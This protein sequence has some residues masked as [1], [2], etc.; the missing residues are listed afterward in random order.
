MEVSLDHDDVVTSVK[1]YVFVVFCNQCGRA[2]LN[3]KIMVEH[4]IYSDHNRP[5]RIKDNYRTDLE[6]GLDLYHHLGSFYYFD[7]YLLVNGWLR[8]TL[9]F[10]FLEYNVLIVFVMICSTIQHH[11]TSFSF[12]VCCFFF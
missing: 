7:N 3:K 11:W 8:E 9:T 2:F 6:L 4:V 5:P 10:H 1:M 12:Y